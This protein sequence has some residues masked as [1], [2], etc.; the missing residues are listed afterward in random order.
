[1]LQALIENMCLG[2]L[3]R[4]LFDRIG[5][6]LLHE[7][8]CVCVCVLAG[9]N[10]HACSHRHTHTHIYTHTH[11]HTEHTLT[12]TPWV[13]DSLPIDKTPNKILT[14]AILFI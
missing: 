11:P 8:V 9:G 1:M 3:M 10:M 6:T 13:S 4:N 5:S 14:V 2:T 12:L 7:C